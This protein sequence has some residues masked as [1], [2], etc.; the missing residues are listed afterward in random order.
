VR[1]FYID[2]G[3]F[4]GLGFILL[5]FHVAFDGAGVQAQPALELVVGAHDCGFGGIG[6]YTDWD[7]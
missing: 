4:P 7:W 3:L 2:I 6:G 1:D 5:P